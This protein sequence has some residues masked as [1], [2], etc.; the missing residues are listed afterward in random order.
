MNAR[1]R[2]LFLALTL[3][4]ATA[5]APP[6]ATAPAAP[7]APAAA[8]PAAASLR[9]GTSGDYP[10]FSRW[11]DDHPEDFA[12]A[13]LGAF[14]ADQRLAL[15][16]SR[17]RW[18][19]HD[20]DLRAGRFDLAADGITVRPERSV[21]GR[22]TVP[23][24][25]GGAVLLLRRPAWALT[26]GAGVPAL[27]ALHA[28]DRAELRVAVN[29]GGHLERV[30]RGLL[31]SAH[32]VAVAENSAVR[33]ALA[34]GEVDAVM[35]NTFEAPRWA[36][37]LEGLER[38]GPLTHDVV[39][40]YVRADQ[41]E[42]AARLDTWL[43]AQEESG[44]LGALRARHLGGGGPTATPLGALLSAVAE[45]LALMPLVAAAKRRS[46]KPVEDT[47]QEARVIE[48]AREVVRR[49]AAERGVAPPRTEVLDAFFR[50]Q[51]EAAKVVQ[52]CAPSAAMAPA[53]S[54]DDDLRPAIARIT[55]RMAFLLVRLPPGLAPAAV[56]EQA[57]D[58]LAG[59]GL[60]DATITALAAPLA[61]LV[62]PAP[63]LP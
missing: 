48:G 56:A 38:I 24:A 23:V 44:A 11:K 28:L 13:L 51:V 9:A 2:A 25:R 37:G 16:W 27:A 34:R 39:A 45:R 62:P 63:A 26:T 43:L 61:A 53:F 10:P 47:A 40:L 29:R 54:L 42:L 14:A 50:A 35:T 55:A 7:S 15:T 36:Q 21:T 52:R 18:P 46:G 12:A 30:A 31:T 49:A 41:P 19:D 32:L 3:G 59:S 58:E 20:A 33:E 1:Q 60:D 8:R 6:A 5:C 17:F 57:R 4:L 22:F